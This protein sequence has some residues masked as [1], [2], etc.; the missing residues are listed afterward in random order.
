MQKTQ[1]FIALKLSSFVPKKEHLREVLLFYFNLKKSA[2]SHRLLVKTYFRSFNNDFDVKS[3]LNQSKKFEDGKL[4]A[5]YKMTEK[6]FKKCIG[7]PGTSL[8]SSE[9]KC[10][11]MCMD[12]YLDSFNLVS[13]SYS[14]RLQKERNRM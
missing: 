7:K 10:I 4:E 1:F 8:D 14:E 9:Q 13:K 11:A 2:A 6:C 5:L 12:R 3:A